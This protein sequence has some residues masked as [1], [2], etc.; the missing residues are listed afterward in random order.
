MPA[1]EILHLPRIL[2]HYLYMHAQP[3]K[4]GLEPSR[5]AKFCSAYTS[6]TMFLS[7]RCVRVAETLS[8]LC[9]DKYNVLDFVTSIKIS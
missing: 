6:P 2:R 1:R 7:Y 8:R 3:Y 9:A 5:A 4:Y